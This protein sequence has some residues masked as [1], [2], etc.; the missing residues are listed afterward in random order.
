MEIRKSVRSVPGHAVA[1]ALVLLAV[2]ALALVA[3]QLTTGATSS[4]AT[5]SVPVQTTN[6]LAAGRAA[7]SVR[8]AAEARQVVNRT[9]R[10]P[11]H[12]AVP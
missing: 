3:W 12:G 8:L 6:G 4:P 2:L 10:V 9:D 5:R 11:T 7:D 1:L